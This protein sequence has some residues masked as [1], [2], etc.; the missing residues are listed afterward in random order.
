[1]VIKKGIQRY[2]DVLKKL[3]IAFSVVVIPAFMVCMVYA[4]T[5]ALAFC[6]IT[7]VLGLLYLFVYATYALRI[8]MGTVV[9]VETTDKVV[10]LKTKRKIFTYDVSAG[11]VEVKIKKNKF[12]CTF[13]TQDS[14]DKFVLL[15]RFAFFG[16]GEEQFTA[17][18][19]RAFC[20]AFEELNY[21]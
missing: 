4:F 7:P 9:G 10:H 14:R 19:I 2:V 16:N 6:I 12:I 8:S 18:D 17:E 20:P 5:G 11:C 21:G 3:F 13:Q 1:M 15:R